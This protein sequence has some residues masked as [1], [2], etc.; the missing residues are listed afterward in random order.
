MS[1]MQLLC[2]VQSR[3]QHHAAVTCRDFTSFLDAIGLRR[4][5]IPIM[6]D[7]AFL[8]LP[9]FYWFVLHMIPSDSYVTLYA[10][11]SQSHQSADDIRVSLTLL[12][13]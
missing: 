6:S 10:S 1:R 11:P 9:L 13:S 5:L 2:I 12:D 8:Q 3:M 7:T 4:S